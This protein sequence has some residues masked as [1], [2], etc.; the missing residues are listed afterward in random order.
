MKGVFLDCETLNQNDLDFSI[1]TSTLDHWDLWP[2]TTPGQ[3]V[4]RIQ[5][6]DLV[7]TN[8]VC[9]T[10][11]VLEQ[12]SK[13]RCICVCA[14]GT[15][16]ID[17][18]KAN[19]LGIKVYNVK[20][21]STASVI[22]HTIGLLMILA[23]KLNDY[24]NLVNQGAWI[25]A[26]YFCLQAFKTTELADKVLGIVGFGAIGSGVASVAERLGMKILV[27]KRDQAG[28]Y[29]LDN[30]LPHID[31]LSLHCPLTAQ[32][33][34]LIGAREFS[35]MKKG[36][37]LINVSRGGLVDEKA[38]SEALFSSHLGGA[39]LDV[40]S[41]EPPAKESLLFSNPPPNLIIT[42][43]VAWATFEARQRLLTQVRQ[44]VLKFIS[45]VA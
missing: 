1:L 30:F 41:Q 27:A 7:V 33:H 23:S 28:R 19:A 6:A 44:N 26:K 31:V 29:D 24:I 20:G 5:E 4:A 42:P 39:A 17:V 8:K 37:L 45:T 9:L 15:D 13:L 2:S 34:R 35:L 38:L 40:V 43:H 25:N 3:T 16:N 22:Q 36:S 21:Y 18:V 14:T 11:D 12:V 10:A 32:T